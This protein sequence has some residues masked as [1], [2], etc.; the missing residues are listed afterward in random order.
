MVSLKK[1]EKYVKTP[2][3]SG[4]KDIF[5]ILISGKMVN[6]VSHPASDTLNS[7]VNNEI[8][9]INRDHDSVKGNHEETQAVN[10]SNIP[11]E[12]DRPNSS[13]PETNKTV[14]IPRRSQRTPRAPNKLDLQI[15]IFEFITTCTCS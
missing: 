8:P 1:H 10:Q 3:N 4:C 6:P 9:N 15:L 7:P 5:V 14:F 12:Y 2:G 11:E 13:A